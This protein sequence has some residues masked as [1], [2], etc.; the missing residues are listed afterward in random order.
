MNSVPST[1]VMLASFFQRLESIDALARVIL[2][3]ARISALLTF[4]GNDERRVLLDFKRKPGK[5]TVDGDAR[6]ADIRVTIDGEVMHDVLIGRVAPG[7]ALGRRE[8]LLRGSASQLA[9]F[10]PMFDFGPVLY[11]EHL[12]DLNAPG[13]ARSTKEAPM[14]DAVTTTE[15]MAIAPRRLPAGQQF[16]TR[17]MNGL[18]Y[19]AGYVIGVIR[20]RVFENL[21]L[22]GL[23]SAMSRGLADA[24]PKPE[25]SE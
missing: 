1:N 7:L 25:Q 4:R 5:V 9:K 18:A 13:Y 11:G 6:D 12:A 24:A 3:N 19:A 2:S 8:M 17:V 16:A 10:I 20:Y 14:P 21:S 15:S 23:L 22:F